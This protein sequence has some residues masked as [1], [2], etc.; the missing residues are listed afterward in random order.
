M[1][2]SLADQIEHIGVLGDQALELKV[3]KALVQFQ[4][5]R[6]I[7]LGL[8]GV[9]QRQGQSRLLATG[10]ACGVACQAVTGGQHVVG[11]G[12]QVGTGFAQPQVAGATLEQLDAEVEFQPRDRFADGRLAL[13]QASGGGTQR[14]AAGGK[15]KG[16][17]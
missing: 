9:G 14:A 1:S 16:L 4:Q 15:G 13:A 12:Q 5:A 17:K 8:V 10:Q 3:G 2:P 11:M 6:F 7:L